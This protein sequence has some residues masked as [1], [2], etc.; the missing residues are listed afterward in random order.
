MQIIASKTERNI[1]ME[2]NNSNNDKPRI[3]LNRKMRMWNRYRN[4]I[5]GLAVIVVVVAVFAIVLKSCSSKKDTKDNKETTALPAVTQE[6]TI[7]KEPGSE[8]VTTEAAQTTQ[9]AAAGRS[10]SISGEPDTQDYTSSEQYSKSVFIGD[11]VISGVSGFGF[12]SESQV[13]SSNS[14]TSDKLTN[15]TDEIVAQS[16]DSVYIMVGINDLNYGSRPVDNIY[17]Y[18]KEFIEELKGRM[19]TT[20]IYVLS[21]LPITKRFESS[22]KVKQTNID[23]L[24]TMFSEN[25]A[26][27][28]ITYIDVATPYKD[29]T[30]YFGASYTDSGYNLKSGYYAFMLNGIAGV[31]K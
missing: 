18:E 20:N 22:S 23:A 19:P 1:F 6:E 2:S 17:E 25:A 9:A 5:I 24:N 29:G 26:S 12:V 16:P 7:A 11:F 4:Y 3:S 27:L 30:G 8:A 15:H 13:I 21:V 10:L 31:I 28:G 14:M